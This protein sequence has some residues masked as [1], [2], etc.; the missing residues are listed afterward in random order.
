[1]FVEGSTL[2]TTYTPYEELISDK[3][4]KQIPASK[5]I[6]TLSK[7]QIGTITK[8]QAEFISTG[9]NLFNKDAV[10]KDSYV[11]FNTGVVVGN[12]TTMH[13]SDFISV[14]EGQT[15]SFT[16]I[17]TQHFAFYNEQNVYIGQLPVGNSLANPF[18]V[19]VGAKYI[20]VSLDKGSL[21][22]AQ[23]E[24]GSSPTSYETYGYYLNGVFLKSNGMGS[25]GVNNSIV[26]SLINIPSKIRE[27]STEE[28]TI[29]YENII[30]KPSIKDIAVTCTDGI[31]S[32]KKFYGTFSSN[33]ALKIETFNNGNKISE[34]NSTIE[35]KAPSDTTKD[36]IVH[37]IGDSTTKQTA[38]ITYAIFSTDNYSDL[39]LIGS[40]GDD[41]IKR[42]DG[43]PGWSTAN[44]ITNSTLGGYPNDFYNPSTGKFDY[45]YFM[46][47]K[48]YQTP[49]HVILNLGIN[50]IVGYKSDGAAIEGVKTVLNNFDTMINSVKT[51]NSNIKVC[52]MISVAPNAAQEPFS[53]MYK[54]QQWRYKRNYDYYVSELIK[55]YDKRENEQIY[56]IPTYLPLDPSNDIGDAVHPKGDIGYP[57]VGKQVYKFLKVLG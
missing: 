15:Y 13:A 53:T 38:E 32:D 33:R 34:V 57:K 19:P 18:T 29:Y 47:Q 36:F 23:I 28:T 5:V 25:G 31:Q 40:R 6:G 46:Q 20:R 44:Y 11:A 3:L 43:R 22:V 12:S 45:P 16:N 41:D 42:H 50:D 49:S 56:L 26:E 7:E 39:T 17:R 27:L 35:V 37:F 4:I 48:G 2:P 54:T 30:N 14:E 21:D 55:K 8:A 52:L 51:F 10:T 24:K 1:M 9:K